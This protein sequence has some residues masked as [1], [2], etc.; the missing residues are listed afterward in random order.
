MTVSDFQDLISFNSYGISFN[1]ISEPT[2]TDTCKK[3]ASTSNSEHWIQLQLN[4]QYLSL[5][6]V[7]KNNSSTPLIMESVLLTIIEILA[8]TV[9]KRKQPNP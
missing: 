8:A 2:C 7:P 9:M 5:V 3:F 6:N 4:S 1:Y